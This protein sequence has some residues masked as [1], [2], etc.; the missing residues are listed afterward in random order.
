M[1]F[2]PVMSIR[3]VTK[4]CLFRPQKHEEP[5]MSQTVLKNAPRE[6]PYAT[7]LEKGRNRNKW[8]FEDL[9]QARATAAF[10]EFQTTLRRWKRFRMYPSV[11][12]CAF[13]CPVGTIRFKFMDKFAQN[14]C[15]SNIRKSHVHG[16]HATATF[17]NPMCP[18]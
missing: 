12:F 6:S 9:P 2:N 3:N 15:H 5:G 13:V 16:M 14:A 18:E 10:S 17:A 1:P 4:W 7:F 11:L 8:T